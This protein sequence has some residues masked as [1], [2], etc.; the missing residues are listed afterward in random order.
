MQLIATLHSAQPTIQS[1]L[2]S[3]DFCSA[4]DLV[5]STQD[6]LTSP[7]LFS[8]KTGSL[9]AHRDPSAPSE[10]GAFADSF[11]QQRQL[12]CSSVGLHREYTNGRQPQL[13]CLR[14]LGAQLT[15]IAHFVRSM[16]VTEFNSAIR[17]YLSPTGAQ[18]GP[19]LVPCLF[20]MLHIS[21]HHDFVQAFRD[22]I[23]HQLK[24]VIRAKLPE[25]QQPTQR[26]LNNTS[27]VLGHILLKIM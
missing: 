10:T 9:V 12:P 4:L 27:Y 25:S 16:V 24:E 2:A 19:D 6:L 7:D 8:S 11:D 22:E 18:N 23:M 15:E 5:E 13:V 20:G 26:S 21:R 17:Y 14:H 1:L 3:N